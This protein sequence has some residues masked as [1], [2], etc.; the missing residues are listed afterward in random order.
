MFK[1][2]PA[3]GEADLCVHDGGGLGSQGVVAGDGVAQHP[4]AVPR[5]VQLPLAHRQVCRAEGDKPLM[6][7]PLCSI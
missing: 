3:A 2:C 6:F 1:I 5:P 7:D 4:A